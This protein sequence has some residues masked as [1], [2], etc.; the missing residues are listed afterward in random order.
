ML[1]KFI[2]FISI[3]QAKLDCIKKCLR[4]LNFCFVIVARNYVIEFIVRMVKILFSKRMLLSI[5]V[6]LL[7]IKSTNKVSCTAYIFYRNVLPRR[8]PNSNL[9]DRP[10]SSLSSGVTSAVVDGC[11][12]KCQTFENVCY[13]FLQVSCKDF[14]QILC[15]PYLIR[16]SF[17]LFG[18]LFNEYRLQT[19]GARNV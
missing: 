10:H 16:R 19:V 8:L 14:V 4:K 13:F 7:K 5:F 3:W 12:G 1:E 2:L 17:M 15:A 18:V 6:A 9:S 11:G